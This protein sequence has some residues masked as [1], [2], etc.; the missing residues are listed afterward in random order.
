[1][2]VTK[3]EKQELGM[4]VIVSNQF[5]IRVYVAK[6]KRSSR[7]TITT[8]QLLPHQFLESLKDL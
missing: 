8:V 4:I 5:G 1:M 7:I 3:S 6:A 2:R